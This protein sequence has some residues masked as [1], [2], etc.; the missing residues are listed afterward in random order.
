MPVV[1]RTGAAI[2]NDFGRIATCHHRLIKEVNM[3]LGHQNL[4]KYFED[5]PQVRQ[6]C[7]ASFLRCVDSYVS[8]LRAG[9]K[10]ASMK[11][12]KQI[13]WLTKGKVK[14]ADWAQEVN[15]D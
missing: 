13:E 10:T 5:N 12:A 2:G 6:R 3:T 8:D 7:F 14:I 11:T 1:T 4:N 9:K 15:D